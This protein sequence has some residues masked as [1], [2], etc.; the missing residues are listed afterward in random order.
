MPMESP[1]SVPTSPPG[2]PSPSRF[3]LNPWMVAVVVVGLGVSSLLGLVLRQEHRANR[4]RH[5]CKRVEDWLRSKPPT[6]VD[7]SKWG[8]ATSSLIN[9]VD[10]APICYYDYV[11][12]ERVKAVADYLDQTKGADLNSML[13][14]MRLATRIENICPD[15]ISNASLANLRRDQ[16]AGE[17]PIPPEEVGKKYPSLAE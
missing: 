13:G 5:E 8:N 10:N 1:A 11:P 12:T 15:G 6:G 3:H 7:T 14:L 17:Y 2:D 9:S 16:V 4:H